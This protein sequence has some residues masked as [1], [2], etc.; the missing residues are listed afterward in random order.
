MA[1]ETPEVRR[2]KELIE[3]LKTENK[4][5]AKRIKELTI[6]ISKQQTHASRND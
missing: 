6:I 2:M 1:E 5:Q 4:Q 3:H